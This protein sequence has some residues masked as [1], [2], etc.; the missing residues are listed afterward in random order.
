VKKRAQGAQR[1]PAHQAGRPPK[2]SPD[3]RAASAARVFST[4]IGSR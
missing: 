1:A 4:S 2:R 3:V